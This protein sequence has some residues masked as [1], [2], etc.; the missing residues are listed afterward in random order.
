MHYAIC[1]NGNDLKVDVRLKTF[2]WAQI[3]SR[4]G[5]KHVQKNYSFAVTKLF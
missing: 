5:E 4:M 2:I 3:T 1:V